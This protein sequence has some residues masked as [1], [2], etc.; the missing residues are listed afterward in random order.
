MRPFSYSVCGILAAACAFLAACSKKTAES[1]PEPA[2]PA[3]VI[4]PQP[5]PVAAVAATP[6]PAPQRLAP[7]GTFFLLVKKS[8]VTSDGIIG[9]KPG[10]TLKQEA[11]G[12][13]TAEGH[14]LNLRPNEITNDLDLA[15]RYASADAQRQAVIRQT[16]ATATA[17]PAPTT[18][19]GT[20]SSLSKPST[21]GSTNPTSPTAPITSGFG[22]VAPTRTTGSGLEGSSSLGSNHTMTKDGWVW[23]KNGNGDWRR[24]KPLR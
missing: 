21:S 17:T 4:T 22:I 9:F 18:A 12:S 23:E 15:A 16:T 10:T 19:L 8:A 2:E 13:F 3:A 5:K 14:K 24:V 20:S 7:T 1:A 6:T 11:D